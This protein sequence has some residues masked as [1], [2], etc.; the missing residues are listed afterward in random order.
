MRFRTRALLLS[1]VPLAGLLA[2]SFWTMSRLVDSTVKDGLR[3]GLRDSH[4]LAARVRADGN[5]RNKRLLRVAGE[6]PSLKAGMQLLVYEHDS[7]I[8]RATVED[9]LAELGGHMESDL[10]LAWSRDG[11][12]LAGVFRSK[13]RLEPISPAWVAS[14]KIVSASMDSGDR[15]GLFLIEGRPMLVTSV[16]VNLAGENL[17]VLSIGED[18]SLDR[19][20]VPVVLLLGGR[21]IR[22]NVPEL[23]TWDASAN[24]NQ[25]EGK[26]SS[27][28]GRSECE[29]VLGGRTYLSLSMPLSMGG[30]PLGD[31]FELRSF[32][33][34]DAAVAPLQAVLR[35]I[36]LV[37]CTG[38]ALVALLI[39]FV[40]SHSIGKPIGRVA[41]QLRLAESTGVLPE[42]SGSSS[43]VH[44]I[45][46]L[47]E[48]FTRAAVSIREARD[49]L[50]MAY[51]E[52]IGSLASALDARDTYTAG[53]SHRVGDLSAAIAFAAGLD[54]QE[55]ERVRIGALLHDIGKIGVPDRIL[56]KPSKLTSEE[57]DFV[58][59]HPV[60]GRRI[61]E[62]VQGFAAYLAAVEL[63]HENWDGSGYPHGQ[64]GEETPI[65]ARIIH[66]AD[67]FDAMTSDRPYRKGMA[68]S[69]AARII[70]ANAGMQFDPV[71]SGI[72]VA[73]TLDAT[74]SQM[75]VDECAV[76]MVA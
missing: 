44:E 24:A 15:D 9:Q 11:A 10:L 68:A 14:S 76:A 37:V 53:H 64:H 74:K 49:D 59:L 36:F 7:G 22:T 29:F 42:F 45:R 25:L 62:G 38:A 72:L 2:V 41:A 32:Q 66:V 40:A 65:E 51:V 52:F 61:L 16:P 71:L 21:V 31:Q 27:C 33:D 5:A 75:E 8:A 26:L 4:T 70:E 3:A 58:R 19:F 69:Q 63:H 30:E 23:N 54:S 13:S 60:I 55:A 56:Q 18:F 20:P 1:F 28:S 47:M 73:L 6:N 35:N 57:F 46:D 17:G 12:L 50:Q 39:A 34:E 67:A 48:S 43:G